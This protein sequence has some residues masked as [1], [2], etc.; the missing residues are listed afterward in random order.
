MSIAASPS[1]DATSL[2]YIRKLVL[3]CSAIALEESKGYL[4]ESR[5]TP[6]ARKHGHTLLTDLIT[7]LR[8]TPHGALHEQ[9]VDAM[10]T[11]ETSFFRDM[12]PFDALKGFLLP[13]LIERRGK[14]RKLNIWSA[15]CS[16]G[17]EPYTI[18]IL[19]RENFPEL[20][21]WDVTIHATDLSR[22]MLDRAAAGS[23]NQ[24]EVNRGLPA[25][26]LV[27]HF[28]RQG[29]NWI[30]KPE[31]RKPVRFQSLNLAAAWSALPTMDIVFMRNVLIYFTPDTKRAILDK[32]YRQLAPDGTLLLGGAETTLGLNDQFERV[33][34]GKTTVYRRRGAGQPSK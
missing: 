18:S 29:L 7:H 17:Q 15:A 25:P 31:L 21:A 14:H 13:E 33:V 5:L 10:T 23:Y 4:I 27:K 11:N 32:V 16:S 26:L 9:V 24:A 12:H 19:L 8:R 30:I 28:D 20:A 3:D 2:A 1:I 34:L 22:E 6:L